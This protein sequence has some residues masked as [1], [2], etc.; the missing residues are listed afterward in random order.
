MTVSCSPLSA[1]PKAITASS[2]PPG[3]CSEFTA[4]NFTGD[5]QVFKDVKERKANSAVG[6]SFF[7]Q[8]SFSKLVKAQELSVVNVT[9]LGKDKSELKLFAPLGC[10]IQVMTDDQ[11]PDYTYSTPSS[12]P[13]PAP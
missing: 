9:G 13:A 1:A 12:T 8:S 4:L 2:G 6:G 3:Y 10:G 11:S 7:G 5:A